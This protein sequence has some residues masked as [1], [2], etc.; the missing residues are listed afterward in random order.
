MARLV[1][2]TQST[3]R[4]ATGETALVTDEEARSLANR[5]VAVEVGSAESDGGAVD[6]T[7]GLADEE[8][9]ERAYSSPVDRM[10]RGYRKKRGRR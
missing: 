2:F 5:R 9:E 6:V 1:R 7:V 8:D 10:Q 4:Y 3:S